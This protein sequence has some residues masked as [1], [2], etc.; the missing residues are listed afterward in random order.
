MEI[1]K[2]NLIK[3]RKTL[4]N[5]MKY[6]AFNDWDSLSPIEKN[7]RRL[8]SILLKRYGIKPEIFIPIWMRTI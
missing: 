8:N 4:L 2:N 3:Q 6:L 1:M 5:G 7:L